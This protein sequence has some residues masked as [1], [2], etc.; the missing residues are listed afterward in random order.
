MNST[1]EVVTEKVEKKWKGFFSERFSEALR[2]NKLDDFSSESPYAAAIFPLLKALGWKNISRELIEALPH[3]AENIDLVDLRNILVNL[4][5][6][7]SSKKSRIRDIQ[8]E[9]YPCLYITEAGRVL[10]LLERQGDEID[11]FDCNEEHGVKSANISDLAYKGIAYFFTDVSSA[12]GGSQQDKNQAGWFANMVSRFRK[13]L[14]HLFAMTF[15]INMAALLVPLFIMLIYDKVI[16]AKSLESLPLLLSGVGILILADLVL[17]YFR[18]KIMGAV[19]GRMDYLIGVETFKQLLYLP[20]MFSERSTVTAQLSRL[21][22]FESVRNFFTG[23]NASIMMELPFV[24]IF[25]I[26]IAFLAGAIALIPLVMAVAYVVFAFLWLPN[27][28]KKVLRSGKARTNRQ[29]MLIQTFDGRR[30]IKAIGGETIWKGRFRELSAEAINSNHKSF[31][32]N[33]FMTNL[34][35]SIMTLTGVSVLGFGAIGV[36]EGTMTIGA[37]IATMALV[38]RALSPIQGAFLSI[39]KLQQTWLAIKQIDQLMRLK[40]EQKDA[41][42]GLMTKEVFGTVKMDRVSFRY[43]PDQDPVLLGVSL[44][45]KKGEIVAI[46]GYTG[47]GKS[48]LLKLIAGMYRPQAGS[49]LMDGQDIRQ[50]NVMELRRSIAYVPQEVQ[51]FHGTIA[52]NMRL[53]NGLASDKELEEAAEKAGVLEDIQKLPDGFNTRVGDGSVNKYPPG[54]LRAISIARALASPAKIVLLDEP[55]TS[56]D[57]ESD[58]RLMKQIE[59]LKGNRTVIIVSHRP[60]HIR[61]ADKAVLLD[62]GTVQFAGDPAEAISMMMGAKK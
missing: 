9:L 52:Q 26:A 12:A 29:G 20:P 6:D 59:Q 39:S 62:K 42:S 61:L 40:I 55:G 44:E 48:T 47:S 46:V 27:L 37:L 7:S 31:I 53:N 56:L 57:D 21:K 13:L 11:Y 23:P 25:L 30:E 5:Y 22:Q 38:W 60:S 51:M 2:E 34:S 49:L 10:V 41:H 1:A 43:G 28:N 19:A 36:M 24:F 18:A 4:G 54:F 35:Q 15:V 8:R 50:L 45:A 3:C 14:M 58:R 17:R 33:A 32:T 16:G